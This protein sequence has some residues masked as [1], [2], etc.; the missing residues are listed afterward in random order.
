MYY[1]CRKEEHN[2]GGND[3]TLIWAVGSE[4]TRLQELN[5]MPTACPNVGCLYFAR[6]MADCGTGYVCQFSTPDFGQPS[7]HMCYLVYCPEGYL[8]LIF[9][10][11]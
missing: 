5:T 8:G 6:K 10:A 2:A 4:K 3:D 7:T 9:Q 1:V 11:K